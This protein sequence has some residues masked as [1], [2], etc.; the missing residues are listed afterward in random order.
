MFNTEIRHSKY[1]ILVFQKSEEINS[2][3]E[4]NQNETSDGDQQ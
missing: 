1:F 4:E 2:E 3:V